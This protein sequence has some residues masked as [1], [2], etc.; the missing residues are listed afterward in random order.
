V[1]SWGP[2]PFGNHPP[3]KALSRLLQV[4]GIGKVVKR[5]SFHFLQLVQRETITH[6]QLD[7]PNI[8][9]LLGVY[10]E[11]AGRAPMTVLPY[12]EKGS[13]ADVISREPVKGRNFA[14]IVCWPT[15]KLA[16]GP[17]HVH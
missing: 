8:I 6:S 3:A 13:L 16:K 2:E 17:V 10:A 11:D 14:R 1:R 7:H 15:L 5:R 12:V 9:P 4:F